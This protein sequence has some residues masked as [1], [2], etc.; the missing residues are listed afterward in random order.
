M[1]IDQDYLG[2]EN[3]IGSCVFSEL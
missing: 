1:E 2:I 3:D